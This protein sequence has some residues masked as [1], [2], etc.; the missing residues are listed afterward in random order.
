[1]LIELY[2]F[3][4]IYYYLS[5]YDGLCNN[6][7]KEQSFDQSIQPISIIYPALA[8][9]KINL[10]QR[11]KTRIILR[12]TMSYLIYRNHDFRNCV[13]NNDSTEKSFV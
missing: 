8:K 4:S 9:E 10:Y 7:S 12:L 3:L 13:E 6:F 2:I 5:I 1:M 11:K